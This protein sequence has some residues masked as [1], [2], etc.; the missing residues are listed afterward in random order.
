MSKNWKVQRHTKIEQTSAFAER[1]NAT[2]QNYA[3]QALFG[4]HE[5]LL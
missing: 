2:Q 5:T 3:S 1:V 4:R